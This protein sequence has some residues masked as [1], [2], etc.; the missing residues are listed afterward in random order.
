VETCV[1]FS[2]GSF[3]L[4]LDTSLK[5]WLLWRLVWLIET[6]ILC[7]QYRLPKDPNMH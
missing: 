5:V 1:T 2:S 3:L 6:K 7:C 4:I